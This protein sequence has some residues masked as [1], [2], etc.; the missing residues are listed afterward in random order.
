MANKYERR[1]RTLKETPPRREN[2]FASP[3]ASSAI[4]RKPGTQ[5]SSATGKRTSRAVTIAICCLLALGVAMVFMQSVGHDFVNCDDNEYIYEN[6]HIQK[7]L[8]PA[9]AWWAI[10]QPHSAN[11]HPLTWMSHMV[12]W[13][14]FG[15]WDADRQRYVD[16]WPGG[17][18]LVNVLL[19]SIC[20]VLLF[21]V[22]QGMTKA[23]WPSAMVAAL[24]AIHPL[25]AES[26]AWVTERKD[27]LSG[28]F[29]LLTL[30]AYRAYAARPFSWWRYLLV[31]VSFALGLTAKPML[32]TLPLV[33]LLLDFWPLRRIAPPHAG[34]AAESPHDTDSPLRLIL[35]KV[36]LL[37]LSVGSCL[38]TMW[39][40]S[41]VAAFKPLELQYR[42]GNALLSY[43]AYIG[44]MF[45][46]AE[47][48]VHY[49]HPGPNLRLEQTLLPIAVLAL[50]TLAVGFFGWRRRYLAVGWL[51]YLGMLVPVIGLVQVGAQARAD[52]YTYLTQIGLYIMI[53][54]G[55][56]DLGRKWHG[57]SALYAL[58][59]AATLT[60]LAAVTWMQTSYWRNSLRLWEHCV[61]CE[62]ETND[63]AQNMFGV[64]LADA[65]P[66][67]V[68]EAMHHYLKAVEINPKYL[69]PRINIAVNLQKQGKSAEA[70][71]V[72]EGALDVD[73]NDAQAHFIKAVA[74]YSL[75]QPEQSI[76]EFHI[77]IEKNPNNADAHNDLA[78]VYRMSG[79]YDEAM[80]A[81]RAALE[82]NPELPEG[83]RTMGNILLAQNDLDGAVTQLQIALRL[84]PGDPLAHE[85]LADVLWRQ[86]NFA[87]AVAQR[88][89]QL[90][91]QPQN[92]PMALKVARELLTDPRPEA[93]FGADALQIA[94]AVC[95]V[96]GYQDVIAL[97][98]LA[99]AYAETGD[100][101]Q[102]EATIRKAM[103]T[104]Q[105]H[106]KNNPVELQKRLLIYHAHQKVPLPPP[107]P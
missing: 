65:G 81:C 59:A 3:R 70:L 53:A 27:M 50:I 77:A 42:I 78:E 55:L 74:L 56:G 88:K 6:L 93:R 71:Q 94:R 104:P 66:D 69:T 68:D 67:R 51:W 103:E 38:L 20:A 76:H 11:W 23:T 101:D 107:S 64:A 82:V 89:Q 60:V 106:T 45:F 25:R 32:V 75:K 9:T 43:T 16:S 86:G 96:T 29:F 33:L 57:R 31:V 40:Q 24:F 1:R 99:A 80:A 100:F 14:A 87:E 52:R 105:G 39:A 83:H 95:E 47:M 62:A 72:C 8:T 92:L 90:A 63:F 54:W 19:H 28:L 4:E 48:V 98:L 58:A 37:A 15:R 34:D 49:P 26:V 91:L 17:H 61:A 12:D 79:R 21:L 97:D 18:H 30:A 2:P 36:P 44:Q 35:E 85:R 102:A 7:G 10:T 5:D 13:R 22:L 73:P 84:K 41:V 46:P